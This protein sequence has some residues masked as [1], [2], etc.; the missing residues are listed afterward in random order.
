MAEVRYRG[1]SHQLVVEVPQGRIDRRALDTISMRFFAAHRDRYGVGEPG[2]AEIVNCRV[3]LERSVRKWDGETRARSDQAIGTERQILRCAWFGDGKGSRQTPVHEWSRLQ[4]GRVIGG[5]AIVNRPDSSVVV[6]P[7][8]T[9]VLT[10][11]DDLMIRV[12]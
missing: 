10:E 1:Q 4:P 8:S 6:P 7:A 11:H 12:G 2:P 3:R 5:P 9:A